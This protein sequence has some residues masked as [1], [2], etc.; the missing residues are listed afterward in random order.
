MLHQHLHFVRLFRSFKLLI[1]AVDFLQ[2]GFIED[3]KY[4]KR[5]FNLIIIFKNRF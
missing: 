4:K 2:F 5:H 1:Q 3:L